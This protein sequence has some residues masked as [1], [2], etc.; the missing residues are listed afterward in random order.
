MVFP[1]LPKV[2]AGSTFGHDGGM[3]R[4]KVH[5]FSYTVDD[6]HNCIIAMGLGQFDYEVNTDRVPW[7]RWCLQ[8]MEL[9]KGS[10]MLQLHPITQIAGFDVDTDVVGHLQ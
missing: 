8:G 9:T 5:T 6:V 2:Q 3:H 1:D 7:C 4:N 10:L